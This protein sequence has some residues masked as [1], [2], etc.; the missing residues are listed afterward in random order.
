MADSTPELR[1]AHDPRQFDRAWLIGQIESSRSVLRQHIEQRLPTDSRSAGWVDP[2]GFLQVAL[3]EL[4][5]DVPSVVHQQGVPLYSYLRHR[6][7]LKIARLE[8]RCFPRSAPSPRAEQ[9]DWS[10][11]TTAD[12][13]AWLYGD[14]LERLA[15]LVDRSPPELLDALEALAPAER[16]PLLLTHCEELASEQ[17]GRV[18][19]LTP[20]GLERRLQSA[21]ERLRNH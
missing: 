8:S 7:G 1:A 20:L 15:Q 17:V 3:L 13:L 5:V 4:A 14:R 19:G 18:T 10:G 16:D 9:R 21:L 2:D 12:A 11:A 6:L